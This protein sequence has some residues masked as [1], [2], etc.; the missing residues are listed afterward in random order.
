M[1][2]KQFAIGAAGATLVGGMF[3]S[4]DVRAV[5][6]AL[7]N[8]TNTAANPVPTRSTDILNVF[9]TRVFPNARAPATFAVPA[10]KYLVI[11]S[12]TG[13]NNGGLAS[14]LE[15]EA[16][17]NGAGYAT[18]LPFHRPQSNGIWY[19]ENFANGQLVADPGSTVYFFINGPTS[20]FSGIN[21]DVRGYY[22][23]AT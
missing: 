2:I 16:V 13:F 20:D 7:V 3:L 9:A 23:P 19:L 11:T 21:I 12:V 6:A 22:V 15:V 18:R 17:A 10:G 14:D 1:W 5:A 4:A 8:V